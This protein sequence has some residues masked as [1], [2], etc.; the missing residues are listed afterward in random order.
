MG[1]RRHPTFLSSPHSQS[2]EITL[3]LFSYER[4]TASGR[5]HSNYKRELRRWVP[6]WGSLTV[7]SC[8]R[9]AWNK[10][11]FS[12]S[13][14]WHSSSTTTEETFSGLTFS[15]ILH[16]PGE[17]VCFQCD[18]KVS[19]NLCKLYSIL[20]TWNGCRDQAGLLEFSSL[21]WEKKKNLKRCI[22]TLGKE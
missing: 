10:K 6:I 2:P 14:C 7:R 1:C 13:Y 19:A 15:D 11:N 8:P 20:L 16:L 3:A 12:K 21:T 22:C 5:K 9:G 17:F 4:H 18:K